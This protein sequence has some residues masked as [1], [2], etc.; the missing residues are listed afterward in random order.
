MQLP[1][2]KQLKKWQKHTLHPTQTVCHFE[3]G[4]DVTA[5]LTMSMTKT[6]AL[7]SVHGNVCEQM[8]SWSSY[9]DVL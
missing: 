1:S 5:Y 2:S 9:R 3:N 4:C 6:G 7:L 8:K